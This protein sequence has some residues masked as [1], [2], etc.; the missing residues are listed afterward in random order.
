MLRIIICAAVLCVAPGLYAIDRESGSLIAERLAQVIEDNY[1]EPDT[2]REIAALL[3]EGTWAARDE[4]RLASRFTELLKPFD[5]HFSVR[6]RPPGPAVIEAEAG[7]VDYA[8]AIRRRNYGFQQVEILRGN[9]GY[10]DLREFAAA[11]AAGPTAAGAMQF[12]ANAH[13]LIFDLRRNGGGDPAMVQL[14]CSYLIE[15][16]VL[17]N[18]LYWRPSNQTSQFWTLPVVPGARLIDKPVYVLIGARTGSAAEEF[19]YNLRA[20]ERGTLVGRTTYGAANPGQDM[21]LGGGWSVFVS[22]GK[23]INPITGSNWEGSGVEPHVD[24]SESSALR[25][26]HELALGA[27]LARNEDELAQQQLEWALDYLRAAQSPVAVSALETL[28]GH[29]GDRTISFEDGRL[30][31]RRGERMA[32]ALVAASPVLF[33]LES[34]DTLRVRFDADGRSASRFTEESYDGFFRSFERADR[35]EAQ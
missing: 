34:S 15:P 10:I 28:T 22:T 16:G 26:A 24:V 18:S 5:G 11:E 31:Y 13:A 27:E 7:A 21:D 30:W 8:G 4:S 19:A 12:V 29:Y 32:E 9:I 35:A 33:Y 6:F 14:L 3:R 17:L 2:G 20:L 25:Q 23:A 1:V